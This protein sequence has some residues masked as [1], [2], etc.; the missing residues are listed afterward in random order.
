MYVVMQLKDH[1]TNCGGLANAFR[2][3]DHRWRFRQWGDDDPLALP[4]VW[5]GSSM[6]ATAT[7]H[8]ISVYPKIN[9]CQVGLLDSFEG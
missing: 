3:V 7:P 6:G 9:D 8:P 4:L 5:V 2:R 1:H